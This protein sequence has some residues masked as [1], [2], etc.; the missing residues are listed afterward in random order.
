MNSMR[1]LPNSMR[2]LAAAVVALV[3]LETGGPILA[4]ELA[5]GTFR[6]DVTP[7]VGEG[8]CVGCMPRID[9]I[10]HPL[11]LR[12][13]VLRS[14][15]E[16]WVLCALDFCGV[17]NASD[18]ALREAIARGAQTTADRVALQSLHQHSAPILDLDAVILL[19][20][21]TSDQA[22]Q[23]RQFTQD[24]GRRA[25]EGVKSALAA[26]QPVTSIQGAKGRVDRVASN[27]RVPQPDGSI[28]VRASFT[29]ELE[30][31][32]APEGLIDPWLRTVTFFNGNQPLAQ[33]HYYATHPQTFYG[34]A[35]VSWDCV[36]MARQQR[37]RDSGVFQVYFTG[38]GGN[39]T[40][41]KYNDG[42]PAAR[43]QLAQRLEQAMRRNTDAAPAM[44]INVTDLEPPIVS[45][46]SAP[47]RFTVR[48]DGAFQ[49]DLL[50]RQLAAEQP[51]TTRL[52][53]AM[54]S[55]FGN[56][57]RAGHLPRASRLRIGDLELIQ[58]PGEPFVEFQLFAQ[59][60]ADDEAFVCVAGYGECGVW[61]YGPDRIYSD[62][63]GYEQ[64]WSVTG[65]CQEAVESTL[66]SLLRR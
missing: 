30:V 29:R 46:A 11:E 65:P 59:E 13:V 34:D 42:T 39:V 52:T 40:V 6:I 36:G 41:G 22:A 26:R 64:T 27:R 53:A 16:T 48:E 25:G 9:R 12:G 24:I 50:R 32:D 54:F 47:I 35:R 7:P 10:E 19:H 56:R 20:G 23:H 3:V 49:P 57:L 18:D 62:R 4:A 14:G 55:G 37:E 17:C 8:P 63:G 51:F 61:Y 60:Q 45:W 5:L 2:H 28:A 38:C 58:L 15:D 43:A 66:K 21:K 33:L 44:T 31:R 1:K